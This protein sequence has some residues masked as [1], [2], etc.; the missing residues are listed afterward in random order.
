MRSFGWSPSMWPAAFCLLLSTIPGHA[1]PPA[2][3]GVPDRTNA[4]PSIAADGAFVAAAWGGAEPDETTDVF[5]AVS[6]D[7]CRRFGA[8]RRVSDTIGDARLNGE[9]PPQVAL[10]DRPSGD[11]VIVI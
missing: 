10:V 6:L 2:T 4:T 8:P 1:A 11:P 5:L 3:L 9:Q 7:A